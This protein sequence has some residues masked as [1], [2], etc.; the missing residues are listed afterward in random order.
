MKASKWLACCGEEAKADVA[1]AAVSLGVGRLVEFVEGPDELRRRAASAMPGEVSAIVGACPG[2]VSGINLAATVV[3]L[4]RAESVALVQRGASGSLRSRAVRAGID[5]VVDPCELR[6]KPSL[7]AAPSAAEGARSAPAGGCAARPPGREALESLPVIEVP[8]RNIVPTP[9]LVKGRAPVV[10]FASGRGGVGKT[11]L[12]A[13]TAQAAGQWG[14]SV[15]ALDLDLSG[16]DLFGRFGLSKGWDFSTP[17]VS[18]EGA[19]VGVPAA[20]G[21]RVAGPCELPE[22]AELAF[23]LV[24]GLVSAAT[25]AFDLVVVDTSTTFTDAVAQAAQMADRLL[26]V[27]D[28]RP[29]STASVARMSGLAVRLGVARTRIARLEN[30][31]TRKARDLVALGRAETGLEAARPFFVPD[32]GPEAV[33][34]LSAGEVDEL[35]ASGSP[36]FEAVASM[37]AQVL[38]EL[39]RLPDDEGARRAAEAAAPRKRGF[40][41]KKKE[42][43]IA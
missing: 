25:T 36:C 8:K 2:G 3:Q 35:A 23:P 9:P 41:G 43:R 28:G 33:E 34:L 17:G 7:K 24:D 40:F 31:A 14:M 4:G 13:M 26:I 22:R 42:A 29:G 30:K 6:V 1:K 21:I 5:I 12:A 32:G 38:V 16:G 39:G 15:L 11:A 18:L 10:V 20:G 19:Q 37:L 27:S